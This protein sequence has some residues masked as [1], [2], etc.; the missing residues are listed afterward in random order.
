VN[1][2]RDRQRMRRARDVSLSIGWF[3]WLPLWLL[4]W[5]WP[6]FEFFEWLAGLALITSMCIHLASALH[7]W[8]GRKTGRP[9]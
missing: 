9:Q 8:L 1:E 5:R 3:V 7:W 2:F 4:A 6:V